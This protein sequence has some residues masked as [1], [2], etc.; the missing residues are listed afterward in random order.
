VFGTSKIWPE[1]KDMPKTERARES[2]VLQK[3]I[4]D[5]QANISTLLIRIEDL[6]A[7][8]QASQTLREKAL[9]GRR[10]QLGKK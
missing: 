2:E 6:E 1:T 3:R 8:M 9:L 5:H 4:V 10:K 7:A